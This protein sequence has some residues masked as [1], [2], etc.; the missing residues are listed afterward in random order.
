MNTIKVTLIGHGYAG[1]S[2]LIKLLTGKTISKTYTPTIGM[3]VGV[4]NLENGT[5]LSLFE[6]A[7]QDHFNF[8]WPDF[9][10]G[11]KL[12]MVVTDSNPQ[13][14]LRTRQLLEKFK[15]YLVGVPVIG[16]A[17]KQDLP[18]ALSPSSVQ[19]LLGIPC[20]GMIAK[21]SAQKVHAY[22][23]LMSAL[24]NITKAAS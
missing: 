11:S 10:R 1:K 9:I 24:N 5:R 14:V 7:G 22:R 18:G 4:L 12:I 23:I 21:D 20:Y 3:D 2:T 16:I 19:D 6:L 17:N 8:L 13:A 15:E